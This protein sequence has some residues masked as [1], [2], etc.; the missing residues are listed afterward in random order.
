MPLEKKRVEKLIGESLTEV[1]ERCEDYRNELLD[2]LNDIIM[3]ERQH[4]IQGTP[5]QKN[6]N[7]ICDNLG[8]YLTENEV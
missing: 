4:Q 5:I 3:E 7:E 2:S 8:K 6:V 1:P